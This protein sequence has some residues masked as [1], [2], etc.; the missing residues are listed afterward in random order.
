MKT[1]LLLL[2]ALSMVIFSS[3]KKQGVDPT[4]NGIILCHCHIPDSD[5]DL[6]AV[7]TAAPTVS[8]YETIAAG[9]SVG[10]PWNGAGGLDPM[11]ITGVKGH[12]SIKFI[13]PWYIPDTTVNYFAPVGSPFEAFNVIQN[14]MMLPE[15]HYYT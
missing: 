6:F 4:A 13:L 5:P 14:P 7:Y 2:I 10:K 3:C 9:D 12:S 11:P 1:I 15:G 8:K